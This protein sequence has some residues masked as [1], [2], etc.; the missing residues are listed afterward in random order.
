[1]SA[2]ESTLLLELAI[3]VREAGVKQLLKYSCD[4]AKEEKYEELW[5]LFTEGLN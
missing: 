4:K 1:M 5:V 3:C 2:T